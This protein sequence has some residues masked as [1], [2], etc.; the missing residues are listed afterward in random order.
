[1]RRAA[2]LLFA[3][4]ALAG[5]GDA[6]R[7][8][9]GPP[10]IVTEQ[11]GRGAQTAWIV[12]QDV[13]GIQPVVLFL[14]GWGATEPRFYRPW[15][16][17][18]ARQGV[19]V[20]YPRYQ[21]SFLMP[22]A[23]ALGNALAGVRLALARVGGEPGQ[24]VVVGHSAGGALAADYAAIATTAKLPVPMAVLALYPGRTLRGAPLSIPE[25][26]PGRIPGFVRIEALAGERDTTVGT[27]VAR[28]IVAG[29]AQVAR[30][31]RRYTLVRDP[32]VAD[33]LGPQRSGPATRRVFWARLDALLAAVR[34]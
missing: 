3:A 33:H 30:A 19:T 18:L 11:V 4:L 21:D 2:A 10:A 24:F 26:D 1:M 27:T 32:A 29:A 14:H 34:R 31:R 6:P 9:P 5:C 22:P 13:P 17:H 23:Q 20:I 8:A 28:R 7:P 15:L 12:R 16:D 25:I